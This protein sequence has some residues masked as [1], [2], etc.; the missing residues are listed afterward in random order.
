M[1]DFSAQLSVGVDGL[2]ITNYSFSLTGAHI[3][4]PGAAGLLGLA[5]LATVRR[6]R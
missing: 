4:A 6:R 5:A 2:T 3:P 1:D